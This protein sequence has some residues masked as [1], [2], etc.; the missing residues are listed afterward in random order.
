VCVGCLQ[1]NDK[2]RGNQFGFSV[3]VDDDV[4]TIVVGAIEQALARPDWDQPGSVGNVQLG[5]FGSMYSTRADGGIN[6][7]VMDYTN[8]VWTNNVNPY[9]RN[10]ATSRGSYAALGFRNWD[11]SY[12]CSC[13]HG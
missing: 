3:A 13:W 12:V 11:I 2:R 5:V 1:P 9:L 8:A 7:G 6:S 10:L 4:G